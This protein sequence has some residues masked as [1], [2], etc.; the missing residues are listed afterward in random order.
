[1][2]RER[3]ANFP[4]QPYET[5]EYVLLDRARRLIGDLIDAG[6]DDGDMNVLEADIN[7]YLAKKQM[8]PR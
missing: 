2:N 1:M 7:A 4:A 6:A 5:E 3:I 8:E